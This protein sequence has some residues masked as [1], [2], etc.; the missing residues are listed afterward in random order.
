MTGGPRR[1]FILRWIVAEGFGLAPRHRHLQNL[2]T[3][4]FSAESAR[5]ASRTS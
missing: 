3:V 4:S 1:G 2:H 5:S